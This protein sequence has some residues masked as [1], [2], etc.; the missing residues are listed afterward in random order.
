VGGNEDIA[1]VGRLTEKSYFRL[2]E[3]WEKVVEEAQNQAW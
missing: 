2:V 1:R 3:I